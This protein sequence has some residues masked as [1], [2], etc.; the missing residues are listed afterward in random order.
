MSK[1]PSKPPSKLDA[2]P[3]PSAIHTAAQVRAMDEYAIAKLD[4]PGYTLMTRAGAA[5]LR[6]LRERWPSA[7]RIAIVCGSGN[8]AGDG[9]VL[10]RLARQAGL[11]ITAIAVSD[12]AK[13]KGDARTA[14]QEFNAAGG[15]AIAWLDSAIAQAD[16]IVDAIFGTG[17]TRALSDSLCEHVH[18]MNAARAPI[19]S[20]D[21]PSGI[22]ADTGR[23]LG[24]AV[25][26]ECTIAFVG[27]KLGF[28][29]GEAPDYIGELRFDSL[30]I[31]ALDSQV[32]IAAQR[33]SKEWLG[34]VLPRRSRLAHKGSNGHVL[35]VGGGSGMA[36]AA[37]LA[38]E[39]GLRVG[40]GLATVATRAENVAAIVSD[41][42]ELIVRAIEHASELAA[43]VERSDVIA[44]GPGLGQSDWARSVFDAVLASEKPL[45][46]DADALNLLAMHPHKRDNWV[47]T[48]HPGEAGRLLRSTSSAVQQ[49]R[50][51]AAREMTALYGGI[52]VLKGARSIAMRIGEPPSICDRGNPAMASAGMGDV[53]TGAIAGLAAQVNDL[54][55]A[56]QAGMFV[57]AIA[58]DRAAEQLGPHIERGLI[59]SDLFAQLPLCVNPHD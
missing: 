50:L 48:P 27:L 19:L 54:W 1:Q 53:L 2:N 56:A 24:A 52:V 23:V 33:L 21:V 30:D 40:A 5:A 13:L 31:P 58:G 7:K 38:G 35:L 59:A 20:L 16:V 55:I 42:P 36:G 9:Y 15:Q 26:A 18:A 6:V 17:L 49:N 41:R 51:A 37:R 45:V 3:L 29:M 25:K 32:G 34:R 57:H 22:E 8:N 46:V 12:P 47:L 11:K 43:L 10:A 28:Y 44:V 14:W 4:I 39:A